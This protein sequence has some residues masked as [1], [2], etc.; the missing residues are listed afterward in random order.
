M[1]IEETISIS[2]EISLMVEKDAIIYRN[3][4]EAFRAKFEEGKKDEELI[5]AFIFLQV[6][7]ECFLHQNMRRVMQLEFE[8]RRPDL[9]QIWEKTEKDMH[10]KEKIGFF[11]SFFIS[12]EKAIEA[13]KEILSQVRHIGKIR[14]MLVHGHALTRKIS[15]GKEKKSAALSS[16]NVETMNGVIAA[17]NRLGEVWNELLDEIGKE[18]K[19][20]RSTNMFK[21]NSI[22]T[23]KA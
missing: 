7:I 20:L 2:E 19:A 13:R 5:F 9:F 6:Y 17:A 23:K 14:N 16:L 18:C 15:E 12:G 3:E 8:F 10:I 4:F 11:I 22:N 1:N 21:F